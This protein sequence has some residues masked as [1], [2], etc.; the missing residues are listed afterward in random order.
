MSADTTRAML[1]KRSLWLP[2]VEIFDVTVSVGRYFGPC[3]RWRSLTA[4][5]W[6]LGP[7]GPP[8]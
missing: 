8:V 3:V 7:K 4:R 5:F 6:H 2:M 1:V